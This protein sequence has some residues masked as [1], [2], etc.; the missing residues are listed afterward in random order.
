MEIFR[1]AEGIDS[2]KESKAEERI[3]Q[4]DGNAFPGKCTF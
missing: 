1:E 2:E 4:G 3:A